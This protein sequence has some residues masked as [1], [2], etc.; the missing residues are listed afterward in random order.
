MAK[1]WERKGKTGCEG[2]SV[3]IKGGR[4]KLFYTGST[5]KGTVRKDFFFAAAQTAQ[6]PFHKRMFPTWTKATASY[7]RMHEPLRHLLLRLKTTKR[8]RCH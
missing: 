3:I 6:V 4:M 2:G 7:R 8:P 1:K 5:M